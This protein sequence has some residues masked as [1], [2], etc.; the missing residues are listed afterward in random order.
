MFEANMKEQ[1]QKYEE[2]CLNAHVALNTFLYD[3]WLLKFSEGYTERANSV[4]VLYPSTKPLDEKFSYCEEI[5]KKYKLP[6]LFKLTDLDAELNEILT[7]RGYKPVNKTDLMVCDLKGKAFT[8]D[9]DPRIKY[10]FSSR[11]DEWLPIFFKVH[12]INDLHNQDV[13][14]RMISKVL[15]DTIYCTL[16]LDD[17]P[18]ACASAAI[19]NGYMLLQNV[20]VS[21]DL[22]GQGLGKKVCTAILQKSLEA[23]AHNSF[24]QVLQTNEPAVNIY[25]KLNFEKLYSYWY[26]KK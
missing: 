19:D 4:S 13:F 12:E 22:R 1:I 11:P 10:V 15:V 18:A 9:K 8:P 14:G 24:L 3:G 2:M 25:K 21:A 5:Y 7:K 20:V 23:G 16:M 6:C 17:K 26:M